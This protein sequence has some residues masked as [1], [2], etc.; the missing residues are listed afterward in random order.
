M[1][2][3]PQVDAARKGGLPPTPR[4]PP[5]HALPPS[6]WPTVPASPTV[7]QAAEGSA[8]PRLCPTEALKVVLSVHSVVSLWVRSPQLL[9]PPLKAVQLPGAW[10]DMASPWLLD[11]QNAPL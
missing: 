9:A 3:G 5:A 2:A 6:R 7:R 11:P 4:R 1:R 10:L 8:T